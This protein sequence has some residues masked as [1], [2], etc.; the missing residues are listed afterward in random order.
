MLHAHT[1]TQ[2]KLLFSVQLTAYGFTGRG[3]LVRFLAGAENFAYPTV[4][5]PALGSTQVLGGGGGS[6]H[7]DKAAGA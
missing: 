7:G 2:V 5:R 4:S 1:N 6:F 3:I